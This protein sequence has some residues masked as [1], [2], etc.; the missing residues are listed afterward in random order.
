M[1]IRLWPDCDWEFAYNDYP[2]M[3]EY[4]SDDYFVLEVPDWATIDQIDRF[5]TEYN[6][7][8]STNSY[9]WWT[10]IAGD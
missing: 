7:D 4:K 2:S 8:P 6:K 1:D 9:E 5:A 3:L 10:R